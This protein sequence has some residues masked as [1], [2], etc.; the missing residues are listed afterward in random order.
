MELE[1]L[2]PRLQQ[3]ATDPYPESN[4]SSPHFPILFP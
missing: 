1:G 3:L 4:E 2:L